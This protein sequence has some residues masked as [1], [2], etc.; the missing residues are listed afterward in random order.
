MQRWP[1]AG[2]AGAFLGGDADAAG[3][4]AS[5]AATLSTGV[6][7]GA[8]CAGSTGRDSMFLLLAHAATIK[9]ATRRLVFA[10]SIYNSVES[11]GL[12]RR[13]LVRHVAGGA[14]TWRLNAR[15][16]DASES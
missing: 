2:D 1:D 4:G 14:P 5:S 13:L 6:G 8:G 11:A 7:A 9:N 3:V 16:N 10:I 12:H 15:L